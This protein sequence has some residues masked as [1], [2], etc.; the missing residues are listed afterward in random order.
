MADDFMLP[1]YMHVCRLFPISAWCEYWNG[2]LILFILRISGL[3]PGPHTQ[4]PRNEDAMDYQGFMGRG[5]VP[6]FKSAQQQAVGSSSKKVHETRIFPKVYSSCQNIG[7]RHCD[8][9]ILYE[10]LH[11]GFFYNHSIIV[12]YIEHWLE[13]V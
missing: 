13:L 5:E 10:T 1:V 9:K 2:P 8:Q 12:V 6:P 7:N 4:Y 11:K 3:Y